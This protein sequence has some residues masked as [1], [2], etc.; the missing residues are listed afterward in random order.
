MSKISEVVRCEE[1]SFTAMAN[2]KRFACNLTFYKKQLKLL[3]NSE[4]PLDKSGNCPPSPHAHVYCCLHQLV[5]NLS[6]EFLMSLFSQ[7]CFYNH[8][9]FILDTHQKANAI[10]NQVLNYH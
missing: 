5:F 1:I 8:S 3:I 4:H 10:E 2:V 9:F 7:I 6:H